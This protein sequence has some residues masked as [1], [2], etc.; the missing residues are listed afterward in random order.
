MLRSSRAARILTSRWKSNLDRSTGFTKLPP[1]PP[2][3]KYHRFEFLLP[4]PFN[5]TSSG[6]VIPTEHFAKFAI[7]CKRKRKVCNG[8]ER[9]KKRERKK[10][11]NP[12]IQFCIEQGRGNGGG[13][14]KSIARLEDNRKIFERKKV[15]STFRPRRTRRASVALD[16][17]AF[18][19][20]I[21]LPSTIYLRSPF[22]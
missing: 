1:H 12:A 3:S 16:R 20:S 19:R 15:S 14:M 13:E 10:A 5:P 21:V 18:L 7:P 9:K 2:P 4:S 6:N 22:R 17:P 8:E 11:W